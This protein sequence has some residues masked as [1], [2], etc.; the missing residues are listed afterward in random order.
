MRLPGQ[1]TSR[2]GGPPHSAL[3]R[4][5]RPCFQAAKLGA[6]FSGRPAGAGLLSTTGAAV[7]K[8]PSLRAPPR[9][10]RQADHTETFRG[11]WTSLRFSG[12]RPQARPC[13]GVGL[14]HSG[15]SEDI[16]SWT[17]RVSWR[18]VQRLC[19][20]P[21]VPSGI[22]QTF[23]WPF[24]FLQERLGFSPTGRSRPYPP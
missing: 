18:L 21:R 16:F 17:Q 7:P 23:S 2:H 1:H 8:S 22:L 3:S 9:A 19:V 4:R 12:R 13:V 14:S 15:D 10:L 11:I 6:G 20:T 5:C 24:L